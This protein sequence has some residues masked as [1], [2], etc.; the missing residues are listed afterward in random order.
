[1]HYI[2]MSYHVSY[3]PL[4]TLYHTYIAFLCIMSLKLIIYVI[5]NHIIYIPQLLSYMSHRYLMSII[6]HTYHTILG[7]YNITQ[8]KYVRSFEIT[9]AALVTSK[10]KIRIHEDHV[11]SNELDWVHTLASLWKNICTKVEGQMYTCDTIL[12]KHLVRK[13]W[14]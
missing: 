4:C 5:L 9:K 14:I 11:F 10:Y 2:I 8:H 6:Y 7:L 3:I 1:M 13:H 12:L